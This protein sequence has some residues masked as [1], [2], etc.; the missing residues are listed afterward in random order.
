MQNQRST[1]LQVLISFEDGFQI[2]GQRQLTILL[3][4]LELSRNWNK[5]LDQLSLQQATR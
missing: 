5:Q 3:L 1:S 4:N 2:N